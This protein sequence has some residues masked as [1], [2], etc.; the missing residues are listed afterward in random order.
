MS[1]KHPSPTTRP[2]WLKMS[3]ISSDSRRPAHVAEPG[4]SDRVQSSTAR[5]KENRWVLPRKMIAL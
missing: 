3:Q 5:A 2:M 1:P 4:S